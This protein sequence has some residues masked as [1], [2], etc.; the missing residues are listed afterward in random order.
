[1]PLL[2]LQLLAACSRGSG[3]FR[4]PAIP[5]LTADPQNQ[6]WVYGSEPTSDVVRTVDGRQRQMTGLL[7]VDGGAPHRWLGDCSPAPVE[8]LGPTRATHNVDLTCDLLTYESL[9]GVGQAGHDTCNRLCYADRRCLAY[10]T[11]DSR[12]N[13]GH[14]YCNLKNCTDELVPLKRHNPVVYILTGPRKPAPSCPPAARTSSVHVGPTS[15][16][17]VVTAADVRL[18]VSFATTMFTDDHVRLSRPAF[19]VNY[20]ATSLSGRPHTVEL[21]LDVSAQAAVAEPR[22]NVSWS[23]WATEVG[24]LRGVRMGAS[25]QHVL[26]GPMVSDDM[27]SWGFLHAAV[28]ADD[29][30]AQIQG[31]SVATCRASFLQSGRLP[32]TADERKPRAAF[33]DLPG[34]CTALLNLTMS[35]TAVAKR[36]VMLG[37][38]DVRA[39]DY[40]G[41]QLPALWT[42]EYLLRTTTTA[43]LPAQKSYLQMDCESC[44]SCFQ[45]QVLD[46]GW[47]RYNSS[48]E[49]AMAAAYAEREAMAAKS[50]AFEARLTSELRAVGGQRYADLGM[51]SYRQV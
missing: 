45:R 27:I 13:P 3:S 34:L 40:F 10:S 1:M 9:G 11:A 15:T 17:F 50:A 23:D 4:P 29:P 18:N 38:D 42:R 19:Y 12:A 20:E 22:S 2:L 35:G 43:V 5:L 51:L 14:V 21:Y 39:I 31:G 25:P 24:G 41:Q 48:I 47:S 33:T 16:S 37:Y 26:S 28:P 30:D 8:E 7:R 49:I 32:S 6:N 36:T 46:D 44:C